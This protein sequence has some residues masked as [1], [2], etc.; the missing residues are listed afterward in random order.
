MS[1]L[2][3]RL[4]AAATGFITGA[5]GRFRCALE[6]GRS[7]GGEFLLSFP[8]RPQRPL[9]GAR[10]RSEPRGLFL[11][12]ITVTA[13]GDPVPAQRW[14]GMARRFAASSARSNSPTVIRASATWPRRSSRT[15]LPTSYAR[16]STATPQ[17]MTVRGSWSRR[18]AGEGRHHD[19]LRWSRPRESL[20]RRAASRRAQFPLAVPRARPRTSPLPTSRR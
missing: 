5:V 8:L 15:L 6:S 19:R 9:L 16:H 14:V 4:P 13:C 10:R 20:A 12:S 3:R 1:H 11:Q 2:V 18:A 7:H 17:R